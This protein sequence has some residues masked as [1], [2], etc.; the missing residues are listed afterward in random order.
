MY[1]PGRF[2][3]LTLLVLSLPVYMRISLS[4]LPGTG[5]AGCR[6]L[7]YA[8][9]RGAIISDRFAGAANGFDCPRIIPRSAVR[10]ADSLRARGRAGWSFS[11]PVIL[12]HPRFKLPERFTMVGAKN[13]RHAHLA[14]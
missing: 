1:P 5:I 7:P 13:A 12:K 2:L 11:S 10:L 9:Q 4:L 3:P 6:T 14:I 8:A